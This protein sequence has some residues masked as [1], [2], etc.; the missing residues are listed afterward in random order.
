[1]S[2]LAY[3]PQP[4]RLDLAIRTSKRKKEAR[5]PKQQLDMA[6]ASAMA[7]RHE[8]V[9]VHDS[10]A[11]E[12]GKTMDRSTLNTIMDRVERGLTDG[13]IVAL[14]DRIGRAPIEEAMAY[15]RKL[16]GVGHLVLA[17]MGGVSINLNDPAV[18]TSLV[19]Q[20]QMARQ[21]WLMT[22]TRFKRSQTDA[23]KKGKWIGR[24][25]VG[26]AK[27]TGGERKGCL[28]PCERTAGKIIHAY[29]LAGA[30]GLHAAQSYLEAEFPGRFGTTDHVRRVLRSRVYRG[31]VRY[32]GFEAN[33]FAHEAIVTEATW[34]AAQTDPRHRATSADYPL[35]HRINC[36]RCGAGLVGAMQTVPATKRD[37]ENWRKHIKDPDG[38]PRKY[39][40]YR[41]SNE[42]CKGG[43]SIGAEAV[44]GYILAEMQRALADDTFRDAFAPEGLAA[45]ESEMLAACAEVAR[46]TSD[47]EIRELVGDDRWRDGLRARVAV[48]RAATEDWQ[49]IAQRAGH[50]EHLP[51]A[52]QLDD[53][54]H[55]ERA[56]RALISVYE[57]RVRPGRGSVE[58]RVS[59]VE[60]D[61]VAGVLPA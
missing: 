55:Y 34:A 30:D 42:A 27:V 14:A 7:N 61:Q 49:A 4:L 39:R 19:V 31:E 24:A 48:E 58:D 45:A 2:A 21:F 20:L 29:R 3:S 5:S 59:F 47:T 44:E 26:Y 40:R 53:P 23:L 28:T 1:M 57:I 9:M 22:A 32:K 6:Q 36:G 16:T 11:D 25:P 13:M 35:S 56:L 52:D 15:V 37:P 10:G 17:D 46:Y 50:A 54:V 51:L 38:E 41:C 43:S 60:R 8:I 12:S 33:L 18:E